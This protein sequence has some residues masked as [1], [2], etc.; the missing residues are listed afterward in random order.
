MDKEGLP[1]KAGP[2]GYGRSPGEV[3]GWPD[4]EWGDMPVISGGGRDNPEAGERKGPV[5]PLA[6]VAQLS[7][8]YSR[9]TL[10]AE[11]VEAGWDPSQPLLANS[12]AAH[13][14]KGDTRRSTK[15]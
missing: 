8:P 6:K 10:C 5:T 12:E 2:E 1:V 3:R 15:K 11:T 9:L 13:T 14:C 7:Q 4:V